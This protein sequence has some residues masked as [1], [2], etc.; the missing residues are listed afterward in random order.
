MSFIKKFNCFI[1]FRII[2]FNIFISSS[3]CLFLFRSLSFVAG[4]IILKNANIGTD[5]SNVSEEP[6]LKVEQDKALLSRVGP[7]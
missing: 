5:N 3:L 2:F 6:T 4:L 7:L 1:L